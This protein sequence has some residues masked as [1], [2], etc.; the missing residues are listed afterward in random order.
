MKSYPNSK[1]TTDR[2]HEKCSACNNDGFFFPQEVINLQKKKTSDGQNV[3]PAAIC[4]FCDKGKRTGRA[5]KLTGHH[6]TNVGVIKQQANWPR[7]GTTSY[8]H[9]VY[10]L[11]RKQLDLLEQMN[12]ANTE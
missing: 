2:N 5:I 8:V 12:N 9:P 11:T 4:S 1:A 3:Y 10:Y 7:N 6:G